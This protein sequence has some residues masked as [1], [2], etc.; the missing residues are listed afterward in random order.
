MVRLSLGVQVVLL[1]GFDDN[2]FAFFTNYTSRKVQWPACAPSSYAPVVRVM[3]LCEGTHHT[4]VPV[5]AD[6]AGE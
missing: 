6:T 5:V 3:M 2:G 4:H 1:K